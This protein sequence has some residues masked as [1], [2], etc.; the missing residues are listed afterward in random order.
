MIVH[1]QPGMTLEEVQKQV[2]DSA[3][4]YCGGN[5][6]DAAKI[7]GVSVRKIFNDAKEIKTD[8]RKS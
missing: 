8:T 2:I 4:R 5:K 6:T 1:W 3:L 7:L